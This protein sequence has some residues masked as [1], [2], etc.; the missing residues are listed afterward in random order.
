MTRWTSNWDDF[1][2]DTMSL[3]G[4]LEA[5]RRAKGSRMEYSIMF[6]GSPRD[7]IRETGRVTHSRL[8]TASRCASMSPTSARGAV[9]GL[10]CV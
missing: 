4:P 8:V 9:I 7:Q 5:I 10:Q 1:G 2:M 6:G 3:A